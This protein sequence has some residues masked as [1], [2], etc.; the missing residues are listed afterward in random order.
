MQVAVR[1]YLTAGVAAVSAAALI[2]APVMPT[3]TEIKVPAIY[4]AQVNLAAASNPITPWLD[5]LDQAVGNVVGIGGAVA[6]DPLPGVRQLVTNLLGHGETLVTGLTGAGRGLFTYATETVPTALRTAGEQLRQ[7]NVTG[8]AQTI[9]DM[10]LGVVLVGFSLIDVVAIP[11]QM[12]D[13]AAR[14]VNA[15]AGFGTLL[16]LV[17]GAVGPISAI[18]NTI[19][20]QGQALVDAFAD[21]DLLGAISALV[22][23]PAALT[24]ALL[25]G[26]GDAPGLLTFDSATGN[27]GLLTTLFVTIPRVIA[28]AL[29]P[30]A[31][32]T[33]QKTAEDTGVSALPDVNAA[34]ITLDATTEAAVEAPETAAEPVAEEA[35]EAAATVATVAEE[36][37]AEETAPA[38]VVE[39]L[40]A[41][42]LEEA[43]EPV[44]EAKDVKR[45]APRTARTGVK[46]AGNPAAA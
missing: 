19:G 28:D 3:P 9:S 29:K 22:N 10:T 39:E 14:V 2:A 8:A 1:S 37:V 16:P 41:E 4:S 34:T 27:N 32:A 18:I 36:G 30:P 45:V 42:E 13:T 23:T 5:V 17:I 43:E 44:A 20:A 6:A 25:N 21:R 7:G 31:P 24:G 26:F 12:A 35:A 33:V 38:E 11:G 40:A 46:R 15:V